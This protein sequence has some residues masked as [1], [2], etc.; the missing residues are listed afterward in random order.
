MSLVLQS[1]GGGSVTIAE[2]TTASDFTQ[3]LPAADGTVMISPQALT[4]PDVTGT[5]MVSGNMPAFSAYASTGQTIPANG[6]L[7]K[8]LL[9][10]E[11]FDTNSNFASS[12]F[13]PTVAGY[14]QINGCVTLLNASSTRNFGVVLYKNG[15][16]FKQGTTNAIFPSDYSGVSVSALVYFNGSTDNVE[17]YCFNNSTGNIG[18]VVSGV[19][20]CYLNGAMVRAA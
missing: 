9:Q 10:T 6:T 3:T 5:V 7:T 14:Y 17:L 2:P 18:T 15:S 1:S 4:I 16:A 13:T 20:F 12:T 19:S 8:V 11:E